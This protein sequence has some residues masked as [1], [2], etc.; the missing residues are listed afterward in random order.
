M[1]NIVHSEIFQV[2][3]AR[4]KI[5]YVC[6]RLIA[7]MNTKYYQSHTLSKLSGRTLVKKTPERLSRSIGNNFHGSHLGDQ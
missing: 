2:P 7:H 1:Y 6:R 3:Y 4:A 5:I